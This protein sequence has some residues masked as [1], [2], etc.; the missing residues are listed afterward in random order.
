[1][2]KRSWFEQLVLGGLACILCATIL[3]QMPGPNYARLRAKDPG[4]VIPMWSFFA[5]R[6]AMQDYEPLHRF[7][8]SDG[9]TTEWMKSIHHGS[10][11]LI[12]NLWAPKRRLSKSIF[13]MSSDLLPLLSSRDNRAVE[14]SP[15]YSSLVQFYLRMV[16]EYGD[17]NIVG[18]QFLIVLHGGFDEADQP[19]ILFT[20]KGHYLKEKI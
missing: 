6:P 1:M 16:S 15:A 19:K 20:S 10:R 2:T 11:K 12:T 4:A 18:A 17:P 9:S 5:P 8:H 3:Q 13:D 7:I 14:A